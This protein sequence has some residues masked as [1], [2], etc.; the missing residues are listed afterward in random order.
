MQD[1]GRDEDTASGANVRRVG[2]YVDLDYLSRV[3]RQG[4][5]YI[6]RCDSDSVVNGYDVNWMGGGGSKYAKR[7][8]ERADV[9]RD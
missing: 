5:V 4:Y 6:S 9:K 3:F 7:E 1:E 2:A 8:G